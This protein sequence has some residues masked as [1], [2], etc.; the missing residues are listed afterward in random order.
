MALSPER[1]Q[2]F[3]ALAPH[4]G[5][6]AILCEIFIEGKWTGPRDLREICSLASLPLSQQN[7]VEKVLR[8]GAEVGI[9][10]QVSALSWET[11][12]SARDTIVSVVSMLR[13]VALYSESVHQDENEVRVVLTRPPKPSRL[14]GALEASGYSYFGLDNTGEAFA[15]MAVRASKRLVVMTP[16]LDNQGA[17]LVL[18][19]FEKTSKNVRRELI[20]RSKD[21]GA[22]PDGYLIIRTALQELGV[23]VF[24]YRIDRENGTGYETFHAKIVLVDD[25]WCYVGSVNMTQWSF[26]Y[27]ME[28]GV[29][30]RGSAAS[31]IS[32]LVDSIIGVAKRL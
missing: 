18:S 23:S 24:D 30:V 8:A 6:A 1:R 17:A 22:P 13:G 16:F 4:A 21:A 15:D 14:E 32:Q 11:N 7:V 31:R 26:A 25:Q 27:S 29:T 5:I 12:V 19:L 28:L 2:A 3:L 20:L 10:R 9:F